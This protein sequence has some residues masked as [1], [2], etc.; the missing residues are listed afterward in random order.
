MNMQGWTLVNRYFMYKDEE[1]SSEHIV[2][3]YSKARL[4]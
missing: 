3:H 2:V 4:L 1:E